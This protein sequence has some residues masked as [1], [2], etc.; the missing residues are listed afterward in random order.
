MIDKIKN[1]LIFALMLIAIASLVWSWYKPA[2]VKTEYVTVPQIKEVVKIQ[3]VEVP[4]EKII[5]IE[6]DRI[7]EK[8]KLPDWI[9]KDSDKQVTATGTIGAYEGETD[10]VSVIDVKT[11]EGSLSVSLKPLPFISF[12]ND[13]EIGIRYGVTTKGMQ[14][15]IYGQWDFLRIGRVH[16]GVYGEVNSLSQGKAMTNI[17][18]KWR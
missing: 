8:I 16:V 3:R 5:T 9:A 11:G 15:D 6:K 14:T 12:E 10:I 1:Y 7:I 17:S 18:Y 13:K 2:E 4:V